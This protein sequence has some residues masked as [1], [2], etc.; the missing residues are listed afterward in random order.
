MT[1][2]EFEERL[3]LAVQAMNQQANAGMPGYSDSDELEKTV[4]AQLRV[5]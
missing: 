5:S 2:E 4:L 1:P 3:D